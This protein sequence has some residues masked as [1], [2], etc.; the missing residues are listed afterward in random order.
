MGAYSPAP[1]IDA[2]LYEKVMKTIMIPTVKAM[3]AEGRPYRGVLYAGLMI[4]NDQVKVLEFNCRFGDPEA[5]PLLVR[6]KNDII[7]IMAASIDGRLNEYQM[8]I[9]ARA[10]V[11]VVMASGGYPGSYDK[12]KMIRGIADADNIAGVKV[13]H[14]GT[15]DKDGEIVNVGGRVL[16]VTAI[17]DDLKKAIDSAYKATAM[18]SWEDSYYRKDIGQKAI[19]RL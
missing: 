13:F 10:S 15:A 4:H 8:D 1:V 3:A 7:P 12:G 5:Q 14:A 2:F 6:M 19:K 18:I 17:G 11:C 9:D 16:G